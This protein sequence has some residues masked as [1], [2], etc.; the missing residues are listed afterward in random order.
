LGKLVTATH[1]ESTGKMALLEQRFEASEKRTTETFQNQNTT[2]NQ[3]LANLAAM[4]ENHKQS[5]ESMTS[6]FKV[7]LH[8]MHTS[9][10]NHH[11]TMDRFVKYTDN[12]FDQI[13]SDT[14]SQITQLTQAIAHDQ[15]Y[16]EQFSLL[17]SNVQNMDS[18]S[19]GSP[20][21]VRNINTAYDKGC[22]LPSSKPTPK[23][24]SKGSEHSVHAS[25]A[26]GA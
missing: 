26:N 22:Q 9:N 12:K 3:I 13:Q 21:N 8:E 16:T 7:Q 1:T 19:Q 5:F 20:N 10:T 24:N 6:S 25:S 15:M 23:P 4:M 14:T 11:S 18:A 2:S 17:R